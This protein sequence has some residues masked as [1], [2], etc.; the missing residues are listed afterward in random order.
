MILNAFYINLFNSFKV[1]IIIVGNF[2]SQK[3]NWNLG[4]LNNLAEVMFLQPKVFGLKTR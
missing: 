1:E 3:R 4:K 2:I